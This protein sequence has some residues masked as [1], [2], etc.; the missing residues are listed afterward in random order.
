MRFSWTDWT[1]EGLAKEQ[2]S[3]SKKVEGRGRTNVGRAQDGTVPVAHQQVFAIFEAVA[4]SF[5]AETLFT[6]FELLEETEVARYF[7]TH[8]LDVG[9]WWDV[10]CVEKEGILRFVPGS[11]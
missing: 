7:G 4:A 2:N 11:F 1:P 3:R 6:L 10:T 9:V 5:G 8:V